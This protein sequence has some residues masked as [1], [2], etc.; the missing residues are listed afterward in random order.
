MSTLQP[1][2]GR[3]AFVAVITDPDQPRVG[4]IMTVDEHQLIE[5]SLVSSKQFSTEIAQ[6]RRIYLAPLL[7]CHVTIPLN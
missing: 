4:T 5:A 3:R 2:P 1:G 7:K 6:G